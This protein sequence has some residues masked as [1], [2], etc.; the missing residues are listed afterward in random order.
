[1]CLHVWGLKSQILCNQQEC[2]MLDYQLHDTSVIV[3]MD[4]RRCL[5]MDALIQNIESWY[6][7]IAQRSKEEVNLFYWNQVRSTGMK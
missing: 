4:N 5:D 2:S 7:S 1:M 6:Q 3:N